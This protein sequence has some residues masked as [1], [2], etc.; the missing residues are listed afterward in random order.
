MQIPWSGVEAE[1]RI[2]HSLVLG[3]APP[4]LSI[5]TVPCLENDGRRCRRPSPQFIRVFPI[6][7]RKNV[8]DRSN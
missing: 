8:V 2:D 7:N 4:S 6:A 1:G 5:F 3:I